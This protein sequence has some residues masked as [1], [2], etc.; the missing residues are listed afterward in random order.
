MLLKIQY[1]KTRRDCSEDQREKMAGIEKM[2]VYENQGIYT[3]RH[4]KVKL[5]TS[6]LPYLQAKMSWRRSEQFT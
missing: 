6:F 3:L 4:L 5:S 1:S 2:F